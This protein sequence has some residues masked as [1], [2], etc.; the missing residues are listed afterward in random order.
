MGA[1]P[2]APE[3]EAAGGGVGGADLAH[4]QPHGQGEGAGP[5]NWR[6]VPNSVVTPVTTDT[7]ENDT[8]KLDTTLHRFKQVPG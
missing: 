5:P 1:E 8:A 3:V 2:G 7:I 4:G 6:P